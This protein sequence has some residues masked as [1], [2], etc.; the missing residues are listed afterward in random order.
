[1]VPRLRRFGVALTASIDD[2]D[3]LVRRACERALERSHQLAGAIRLDSHLYGIMRHLWF[4]ETRTCKPGRRDV[5]DS[6]SPVISAGSETDA[7]ARN[8]LPAVRHALGSLSAEGRSA[9]VLVCVDGLSYK[10]AA[11][12]L[13]IPVGTL[14]SRLSGARHELHHRLH[15]NDSSDTVTAPRLPNPHPG[16]RPG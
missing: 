7:V 2:G 5:G 15:H 8:S 10:E 11:E 4:D 16:P 9:L 13:A 1:M 3:D 12:V 6:A 14:M